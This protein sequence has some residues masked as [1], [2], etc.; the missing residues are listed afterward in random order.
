MSLSTSPAGP[1][2]MRI[3][4]Q[5]VAK[6]PSRTTLAPRLE[7][8]SE[9]AAIQARGAAEGSALQ[10]R[11]DA[12]ATYGDAAV[13]ELLVRVLPDVVREASAPL[14]AVDKMT[15]ISTDG[16]SSL[17]RTVAGGVAQGLELTSDLT[18]VDVAALLGRLGSAGARPGTAPA[19]VPAVAE[20]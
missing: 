11:A 3:V 9:A 14:A 18:G 12:L 2:L 7:G 17:G 16:A 20:G 1:S 8:A 4:R 6:A 15:I 10:A 19:A 5:G 13:L